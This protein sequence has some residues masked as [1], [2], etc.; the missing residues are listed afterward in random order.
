MSRNADGS[1][2]TATGDALPST[3][4]LRAEPR[5]TARWLRLYAQ[6]VALTDLAILLFAAAAA[7]FL[8]FRTTD[9][10]ASYGIGYPALGVGIVVM[11]WIGLQLAGTRSRNVIGS[12]TREYQLVVQATIFVFGLLAI[13]SVLFKFDMSRVYLALTFPLG[14]LGLLIGRKMWRRW[15]GKQRASG[16]MVQHVLVIG[17]PDSASEISGWFARHRS[18]GFRVTGVWIPDK[19]AHPSQWLKVADQFIP[20]FRSQRTFEDALELTEADAVIVSDADHLGHHGLRELTW[21]L[22]SAGTEL[23]VSPN[24]VDIAGFRIGMRNVASMPFLHIKEPQYAEAGA[25]PKLVFDRVGAGVIVTLLSPIL[26]AIALIVKFSSPGPI[27]YRQERIGLNGE[28]FK[29]T[30]FRSMRVGADDELKSLLEA[31]GTADQPLFKVENDPRVT[32]IGGFIRRYSIDELP[33]LFDVLR[34]SMSLVGPRPQR[35]EEVALYKDGAH[36]RLRVR[37]GMTGLWQV[38]GRSRLTWEEAIQLDTSYVENWS[39]LGDLQILIRTVR[40]V[41]ARD[42][43]Y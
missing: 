1:T 18:A 5:P 30:K 37:P 16:R 41:L 38:S 27:C 9:A 20:V 21:H 29:M 32:K 13:F 34:G 43:A 11:W 4:T 2:A 28:P 39:M 35:A 7:Q 33:Q 10:T 14:M 8:R 3:G 15:L 25:W 6:Q 19:A 31:Q 42:G 36:R 22:D 12:G 40:A 17:S 26:L 23:F 24:M